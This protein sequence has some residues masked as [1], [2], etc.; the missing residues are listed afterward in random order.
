LGLGL[1]I[2]F[3]AIIFASKSTIIRLPD[4]VINSV[5]HLSNLR[6]LQILSILMAV[7]FFGPVIWLKGRVK[8]RKRRIE[9]A[10]PNALDLVQIST[11]AGLGFDAAMTRVGN[12]LASVSPDISYEFLTAQ[13]EI[14]AGRSREKALAD[15]ATRTGVEEIASFTNVVLQSMQFG[16]PIS[17]ALTAYAEEMRKYREL[18]AQE[19]A[20]K[21][22]VKMSGVMASL[23]LPALLMITIGPVV[24]RYIRFFSG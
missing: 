13:R 21:L 1:S 12:E 9:E 19:Q 23:M 16:T 20:N 10:F 3:I 2:A 17:A 7:G 5:A 22:P 15:I 11:E 4:F 14:L 6:T 18:R 24:I 8:D